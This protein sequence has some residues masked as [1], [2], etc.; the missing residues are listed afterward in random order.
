[1]STI[2]MYIINKL[3]EYKEKREKI[4]YM[5]QITNTKKTRS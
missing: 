5:K 1:M 4:N 3:V 2:I